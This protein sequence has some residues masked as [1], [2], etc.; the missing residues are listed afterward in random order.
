[1][2]E[3][4]K[5]ESVGNELVKRAEE[6]GSIAL[7]PKTVKA[8]LS[9]T[10]TEQ[11]I[12]LFLNQCAMFGLNPFKREIY[13]IK[14]G[15]QP[16]TFVVGYE[17]YLKRADRSE[18]WNGL[19]SGT[20]GEGKDLKAWA[21]VYRK[22]W[23]APLYHEVYLEE[24]VQKKADGSPTRFWSEKPRTMLKKVAISQ[25]FRMAFPDEFSGMPYTADEMPVDQ[26]KLPKGEVRPIEDKAGP[27]PAEAGLPGDKDESFTLDAE[28]VSDGLTPQQEQL[29]KIIA[30]VAEQKK[31]T[32]AA[33]KE[34]VK[35][36]VVKNGEQR[37]GVVPDSLSDKQCTWVC[38][39]LTA[40]TT[41][42]SRE[43]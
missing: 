1:M 31:T 16:A 15:S 37:P 8:Y 26:E 12:A 3:K 13:L 24:Y 21:K 32:V 34:K 11:E 42:E 35:N 41:G 7:N 30:A 17:V 2:S 19:E 40:W 9:Q 28:V 18:K 38:G 22:D 43:M 29:N 39:K 14:Y 5:E 27:I 10:A 25:A 36:L 33:L 4:P 23:T 6:A 20:S